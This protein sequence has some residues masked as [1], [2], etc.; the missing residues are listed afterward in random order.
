M[1]G[2]Q[3]EFP[4]D[5][6]LIYLNHAAVGVWPRRTRDAVVA[7]ADENIHRGAAGYPEWMKTEREYSDSSRQPLFCIHSQ[8]QLYIQPVTT[9]Q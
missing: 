6:E 3:D 1:N 5:D 7:F 4:L 9:N 8:E 2:Y